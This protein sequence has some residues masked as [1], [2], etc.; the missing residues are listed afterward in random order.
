M[1]WRVAFNRWTGYGCKRLAVS[2]LAV[3]RPWIVGNNLAGNVIGR[4]ATLEGYC[5]RVVW[6]N[7]LVVFVNVVNRFR[8]RLLIRIFVGCA[9]VRRAMLEVNFIGWRADTKLSTWLEAVR[10]QNVAVAFKL[11]DAFSRAVWE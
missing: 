1:V 11:L 4:V 9:R 7:S 6:L 2:L 10:Y 5:C 8:N 3:N